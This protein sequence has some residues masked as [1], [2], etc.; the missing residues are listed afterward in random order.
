MIYMN[1][2]LLYAGSHPNQIV[3]IPWLSLLGPAL[4]YPA[5]LRG[6]LNPCG[7]GSLDPRTYANPFCQW[8]SLI[9][10]RSHPSLATISP[11]Y[12]S[13]IRCQGNSSDCF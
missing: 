5:T 7:Y 3:D 2:S 8:T 11:A 6:S 1:N 12:L 10:F 13:D 4:A 9:L